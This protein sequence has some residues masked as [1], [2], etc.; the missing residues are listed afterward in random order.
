MEWEVKWGSVAA[1]KEKGWLDSRNVVHVP[2]PLERA[3]TNTKIHPKH[4]MPIPV[5]F[6]C[7][8]AP[9]GVFCRKRTPNA[10]FSG[11]C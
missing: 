10:R 8:F 6:G 1:G 7:I 4:G 9:V 11:G 2:I 3:R 5:E